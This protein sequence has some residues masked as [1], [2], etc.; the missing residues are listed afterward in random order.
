VCRCSFLDLPVRSRPPRLIFTRRENTTG[1]SRRTALPSSTWFRPTRARQRLRVRD[2]NGRK[3]RSPP[4]RSA[5]FYERRAR[6]RP[7]TIGLL[8]D[9]ATI[10]ENG[11]RRARNDRFPSFDLYIY[12]IRSRKTTIITTATRAIC[13]I[14]RDGTTQRIPLASSSATG[15][16]IY[17]NLP[18][19]LTRSRY[20]CPF[21]GEETAREGRNIIRGGRDGSPYRRR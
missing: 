5:R 7:R 15:V 4:A 10:I 21:V 6:K 9:G 18:V 19:R 1:D 8:A 11:R 20:V 2:P 17:E 14:A 13:F 16:Y 3:R 12:I